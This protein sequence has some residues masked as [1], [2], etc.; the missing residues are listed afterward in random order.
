M[1]ELPPRPPLRRLLLLLVEVV[2][3]ED[4][5]PEPKGPEPK[6]PEPSGPTL[7]TR[8]GKSGSFIAFSESRSSRNMISLDELELEF[9]DERR[10][11]VAE[12]GCG[13]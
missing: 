5:G 8:L 7:L 3:I 12:C 6:G 11:A 9:S 4:S 10:F 13:A 1:N 2:A